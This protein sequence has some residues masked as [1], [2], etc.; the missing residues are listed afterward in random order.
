[1]SWRAHCGAP[2][3]TRSAVGVEEKR[4]V[5]VGSL[6]VVRRS[7]QDVAEATLGALGIAGPGEPDGEVLLGRSE[8]RVDAQRSLQRRVGGRFVAEAVEERAE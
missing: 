1:M 8:G 5:V 3:A 2:V 6:G 7:G 4:P